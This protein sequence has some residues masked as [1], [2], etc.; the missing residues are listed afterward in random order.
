MGNLKGEITKDLSSLIR[1]GAYA[2]FEGS[3]SYF[4]N[5]QGRESYQF[6]FFLNQIEDM[7]DLAEKATGRRL[8]KDGTHI[9]FY[10]KALY[11]RLNE[12]GFEK[13]TRIDWNIP[14]S[15]M[16]SESFKKEYFRALIDGLGNVDIDRA[17]PYIKIQSANNDTLRHVGNLFGG[18]FYHYNDKGYQTSYLK[19]WGEDALKILD[20]LDWKFYC[21][22]NKRGAEVIKHVKW[23]KV[24]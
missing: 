19:W 23:E 2:Q 8:E 18:K 22:R 14:K 21:H 17:T 7:L 9:R 5:Q 15:I 3:C 4:K 10:S 16:L 11:D 6:V 13:F 1:I 12:L 20:Y 24:V